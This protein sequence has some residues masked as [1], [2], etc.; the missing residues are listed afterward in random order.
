[1]ASGASGFRRDR[2]GH[3]GP[4][5]GPGLASRLG[6]PPLGRNRRD[7][8]LLHD[9]VSPRGW[10]TSRAPGR[11][12]TLASPTTVPGQTPPVRRH[13]SRATPRA[14]RARRSRRFPVKT[15]R[16]AQTSSAHL[17][18]PSSSRGDRLF[19]TILCL[20]RPQRFP[21]WPRGLVGIRP[22]LASMPVAGRPRN[23][24]ETAPPS[25]RQLQGEGLSSEFAPCATKECKADAGSRV[26]P[27]AR[28]FASGS[29]FF[30][31]SRHAFVRSRRWIARA[32]RQ[33]S[34]FPRRN[35][36][37]ALSARISAHDRLLR[38]VRGFRT[39]TGGYDGSD[40]G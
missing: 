4:R 12:G 35:A 2:P 21:L 6:A 36:R 33:N 19:V 39:S 8:V 37:Q 24:P 14:V 10:R 29:A 11:R 17:R 38:S 25:R 31:D 18:S 23:R 9:G 27:H 28:R 34:S 5:P 22:A 40:H 32:D 7:A 3:E 26:E 1:M 30:D 16:G 15:W 13:R 20:D